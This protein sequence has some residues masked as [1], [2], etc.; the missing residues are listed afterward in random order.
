MLMYVP[1][2]FVVSCKSSIAIVVPTRFVKFNSSILGQDDKFP[3]WIAFVRVLIDSEKDMNE[4]IMLDLVE[5]CC[6]LLC[7]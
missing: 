4:N 7:D 1:L 2:L 5:P 3:F 6:K